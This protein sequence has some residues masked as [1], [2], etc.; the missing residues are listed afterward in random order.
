MRIYQRDQKDASVFTLI[1]LLVVIAII[2]IL[3]AMLLPA[4]STAKEQ[5]KSISCVNNEKQVIL[6]IRSYEVDYG[7]NVYPALTGGDWCKIM[8][9]GDYLSGRLWKGLLNASA[10]SLYCPTKPLYTD[11]AHNNPSNNYIISYYAN[12]SCT[13]I[14]GRRSSEV[15]YPSSTIVM[16]EIG[17]DESFVTNILN[18]QYVWGGNST[19]RIFPI[20]RNNF[21]AAYDDGH[22]EAQ[23]F[24][25]YIS[26]DDTSAR[27]VWSRTFEVINHVLK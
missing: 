15:K 10:F 17:M 5:A 11:A 19:S 20:H 3:A 7:W 27:A 2:A 6:A 13:G 1:E 16:T 4:L 9:S 12:S 24:R 25:T 26:M 23:D 18:Y 8:I 22:I 21:N 14:A